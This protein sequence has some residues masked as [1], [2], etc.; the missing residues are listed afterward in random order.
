MILY[1]RRHCLPGNYLDNLSRVPIGVNQTSNYRNQ[2]T[3]D[4]P[5]KT[6]QTAENLP[7]PSMRVSKDISM[8][9]AQYGINKILHIIDS[10]L[11][12]QRF[13]FI[14]ILLYKVEGEEKAV[15]NC[16]KRDFPLNT[17]YF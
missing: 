2:P 5:V 7:K 4:F 3:K 14:Q 8:K 10:Y 12:V 16:P 9:I 11:T 17:Y 15:D 13:R 6:R 1:A